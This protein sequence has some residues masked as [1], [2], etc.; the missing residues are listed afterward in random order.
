MN[1]DG[2]ADALGIFNNNVFVYLSHGDGTFAA[3]VPYAI[4]DTSLGTYLM[5][6]GDFKGDHFTDNSGMRR[7]QFAIIVRHAREYLQGHCDGD[8]GKRGQQD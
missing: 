1:G 4:G 5:T 7:Q 8:F 6:L 2:K 3:G